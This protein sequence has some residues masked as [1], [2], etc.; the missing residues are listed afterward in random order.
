MFIKQESNNFQGFYIDPSND[1]IPEQLIQI[2]VNHNIKIEQLTTEQQKYANCGPEVI[3]N[4]MLY[5]T[6]ERL[7]QEEAI[8]FH[9]KLV[10]Q[11]LMGLLPYHFQ[12]KITEYEYIKEDGQ[13]S[14]TQDFEVLSNELL[15][16]TEYKG[17]EDKG[18]EYKDSAIQQP[19]GSVELDLDSR[20]VPTIFYANNEI[21]P[22]IEW[23]DQDVTTSITG[24]NSSLIEFNEEFL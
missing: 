6:G 20:S 11:K 23:Q 3:E 22:Y 9:S 21:T 15:N 8:P 5:L 18:K 7:S 12:E 1:S 4:F 17:T 16:N 2:F 19:I 14:H 10:E 13:S 24:L